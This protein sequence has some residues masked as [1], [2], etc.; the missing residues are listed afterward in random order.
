M[1]QSSRCQTP[2]PTGR[3]THKTQSPTVL[4][5]TGLQIYQQ[6]IQRGPEKLL[7]QQPSGVPAS[8]PYW[9]ISYKQPTS[10]QSVMVQAVQ[11]EIQ[12]LQSEGLECKL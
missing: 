7:I 1:G 10:S 8:S 12:T 5:Q 3:P 2:P 9:G 4:Q 6:E 11:P